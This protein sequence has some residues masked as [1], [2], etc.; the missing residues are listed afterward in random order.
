MT[1]GGRTVYALACCLVLLTSLAGFAAS[2]PTRGSSRNGTTELSANW[3]IFGPTAAETRHNRD[4]TIRTQYLCLNQDFVNTH[5]P[6]DFENSGTC[7]SGLITS[8][9]ISSRAPFRKSRWAVW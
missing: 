4:L 7:T 8:S 2:L 5:D 6:S 3:N 1:N 9:F